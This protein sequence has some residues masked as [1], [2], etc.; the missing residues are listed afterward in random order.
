M[1]LCF[2]LLIISVLFLAT[3]SFLSNFYLFCDR[4]K[5]IFSMLNSCKL[6]F[7]WDK[8]KGVKYVFC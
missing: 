7:L 4:Q 5:S 2:N 3:M 1:L 8:R 6:D